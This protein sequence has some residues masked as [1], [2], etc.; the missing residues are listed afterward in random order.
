[1]KRRRL[2][3]LLAVVLVMVSLGPGL[4][5]ACSDVVVTDGGNIVV[6]GRTMDFE[7]DL[8]SDVKIVPRGQ[9]VVSPAP[10]GKPGVSWTSRYGFVGV[11]AL[12]INKYVDGLNEKGLSIGK[13]WL[14]ETEY[15]QPASTGNALSIQDV[16]EWVLGNFATVAEVKAALKTVVIWGQRSEEI[17]MV[18]TLHLTVHDALGASLVVEF[19]KGEMHVYDNPGGVMT[20]GPTFD[21]Q[22]TNLGYTRP[23]EASLGTMPGTTNSPER[24]LQLSRLKDWLP[25]PKSAR[26]AAQFAI[27]LMDRV[28]ALPGEDAAANPPAIFRYGASYTEWTVVRDHTNLVYMYKTTMNGSLRGVDLK[29]LDLSVGRPIVSISMEDDGANWYQDVSAR[30]R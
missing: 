11:N 29:T 22:L 30:M 10:D 14:D 5:S 23:R 4:A 16:G 17:K 9:K 18:P 12:D 7:I 3:W 27:E 1:V 15:P 19:V 13:L 28:E 6:S 20:N 21:W 2:N 26:E 25:K 24:F 8:K